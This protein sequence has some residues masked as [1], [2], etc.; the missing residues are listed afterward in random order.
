MALD[1]SGDVYVGGDFTSINGTAI[2]YLARLN[3]DGSVDTAFD[4][5]A[6]GANNTVNVI[7][8]AQD[9]SGDVYVGGDFFSINTTTTGRLARLDP[10]GSVD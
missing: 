2:N 5:S 3:S 8:P 7:T 6:G 10:D 9:G 1:G 4:M